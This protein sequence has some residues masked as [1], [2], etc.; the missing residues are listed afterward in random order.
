MIDRGRALTRLQARIRACTKCVDAGYL[1]R[2]QPIVAGSVRDRVAIIGQAPGEVELTTGKPFSGRAGAELRRWL[3]DAGIDEDRLPYRTSITKCFPGKSPT[4]SGDR[5]PSPPEI[6][7]CAPW[8][9][10]ELA[11]LE[12]RVILLVGGLAIE[13]FWGRVPLESAVGSVRVQGGVT[14]IPLPHPSGASRWLNDPAHRELLRKGL[15]H[16]RRAARA[17]DSP[18]RGRTM[19]IRK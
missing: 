18:S 19:Q 6:A 1:D 4:G 9:E 11:L 14:F 15:A 2:A 8:L 16:L 17:L 10:K 12:P 5:R 7:L 3:A 13:R